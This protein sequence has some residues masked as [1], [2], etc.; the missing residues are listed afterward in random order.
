MSE[1]LEPPPHCRGFAVA[2]EACFVCSNTVQAVMKGKVEVVGVQN[3]HA[4]RANRCT[5]FVVPYKH[6]TL[7]LSDFAMCACTS[8]E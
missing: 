2:I 3:C 1:L 7:V 4:L 5:S 6:A 8:E